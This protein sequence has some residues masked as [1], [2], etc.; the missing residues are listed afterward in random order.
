[1]FA[2]RRACAVGLEPYLLIRRNFCTA[3]RMRSRFGT[4]SISPE[5]TE[6]E[7]NGTNGHAEDDQGAKGLKDFMEKTIPD[8]DKI[9]NGFT[10][11]T[12]DDVEVIGAVESKEE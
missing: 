7:T 3:P 8:T 4:I 5:P 9:E 10:H 6:V 2:L 1:M 11:I 12:E